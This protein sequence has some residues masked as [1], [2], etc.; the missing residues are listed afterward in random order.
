[1]RFKLRIYIVLLSFALG[2]AAQT[3]GDNTYEFL[4]LSTFSRVSSLGGMNVSV[5]TGNP[6]FSLYNPALLGRLMHRNLALN[7]SNYIA[8]INYGSAIYTKHIETYGSFAAGI[9]YLNYGKFDRADPSGN[10]NGSFTA[11]E[12][13]LNL[14][15]SYAIDSL[16]NAAINIKP[17]FS[18]LDSYN[19][20]GIAFDLG[21]SYRS[22]DGLY[23]A[24][25]VV[26]NIGTQISTYSGVRDRLPFEI[27]AG[28]SAM[29]A[30][31]PFRL[32]LTARNLQK[33]RLIHEYLDPEESGAQSYKGAGEVAENILRHLIFGLELLPSD[34]FYI[35]AGFNYKLRKEM[36]LESRGSTVGFSLG[37]GIMLSNMELSMSRSRFHLAGSQTSI[38]ILLKP[39]LF[40]RKN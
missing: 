34:N 17:V 15:W 20:L 9:N 11:S 39:G 26:R 16:F 37:A 2:A 21:V 38:S 24:G 12:Y 29:L 27:I 3:G 28:A 6:S 31:A 1:M 35:A 4:N 10:I 5:N 7:Y 23:S 8:G 33:Y 32:S 14:I 18:H 40:D 19:S 30:H 22:R 25:L 36:V 13:A